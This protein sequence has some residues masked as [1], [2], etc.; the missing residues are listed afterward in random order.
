MSLIP[1]LK[2]AGSRGQPCGPVVEFAPCASVAKGFAGSD[3]GRRHG[4]ARQAEEASHIAQ[5]EGPTTRIHNYVLRSFGEK[6]E[7][8]KKPKNKQDPIKHSTLH[9]L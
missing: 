2:Q 6:K 4:R 5:L 1:F 9:F 8:F 3:P 7:K